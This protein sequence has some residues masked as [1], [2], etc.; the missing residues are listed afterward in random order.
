[1]DDKNE[2]ARKKKEQCMEK[3]EAALMPVNKIPEDINETDNAE[4]GGDQLRQEK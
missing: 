1:M 3:I 2:E 4:S